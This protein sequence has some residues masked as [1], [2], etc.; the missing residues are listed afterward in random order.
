MLC[1]YALPATSKCVRNEVQPSARGH[2]GT[3][4]VRGEA[5]RHALPAADGQ[6][7]LPCGGAPPRHSS[8]PALITVRSTLT[9]AKAGD[10][11]PGR[12][13]EPLALEIAPDDQ[14]KARS[15]AGQS[16]QAAGLRHASGVCSMC[17]LL[18]RR[19]LPHTPWTAPIVGQRGECLG[20]TLCAAAA[21]TACAC[22]CFARPVAAIV[23]H[24]AALLLD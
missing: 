18:L 20:N 7:S 17:S 12:G 9:R 8:R 10:P 1:P 4:L 15:E 5:A 22:W 6:H 14:P 2:A 19:A 21:A 13:G 3:R 11:A 16:R 23:C 24:S